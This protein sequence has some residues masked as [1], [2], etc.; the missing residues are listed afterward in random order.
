MSQAQN[1]ESISKTIA[2][3]VDGPLATVLFE[4]QGK[5]GTYEYR[6]QNAIVFGIFGDRITAFRE[7][8]G[9]VDPGFV[10]GGDQ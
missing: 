8:L 3:L 1:R 7:F 2:I 9:D 4:S 6:A 10:C 5:F